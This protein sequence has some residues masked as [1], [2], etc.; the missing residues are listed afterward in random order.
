MSGKL[1]DH[2]HLYVD[3]SFDPQGFCGIGG[4]C[5]DS[6]GEALGF[7]SEE[8]PP[9]LLSLLLTGDT[10]TAI[11]ELEALAIIM[12][13]AK[14]QS[15]VQ[16][17]KVVLSTDN[18]SVRTSILRGNSNNHNVDCMMRHLFE[19]EERL[20]F[21]L[22][23]ERVPSQSNPADE[24]SRKICKVLKSCS[25]RVRVD[26]MDFEYE[27][28]VPLGATARPETNPNSSKEKECCCLFVRQAV[29]RSAK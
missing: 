23:L 13:I 24:P 22:W 6:Q 10:E 25:N 4:V 15:V 1:S 7:F 17:H 20:G 19:E 28:P 8:V 11:L 9:E 14:W 18:E 3:A 16:T 21:Q 12:A 2:V 27:R 26:V 5:Y 29:C